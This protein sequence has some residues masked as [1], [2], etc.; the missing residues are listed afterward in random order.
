MNNSPFVESIELLGKTI[1]QAELDGQITI[2]LDVVDVDVD[3]GPIWYQLGGNV[4]VDLRAGQIGEGEREIF[5]GDWSR[6]G[7]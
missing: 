2:F 1:L 7:G 6:L 4:A 5:E 3:V